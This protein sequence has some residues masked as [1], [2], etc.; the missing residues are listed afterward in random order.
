MSTSL[1]RKATFLI[2][3]APEQRFY[4]QLWRHFRDISCPFCC[5]FWTWVWLL[6]FS[7]VIGGSLRWDNHSS[8]CDSLGCSC[9]LWI[10]NSPVLSPKPLVYSKL[11]STFRRSEVIKWVTGTSGNLVVKSKLSPLSSSAALR[12]LNSIKKCHKGFY[13]DPKTPGTW[14]RGWFP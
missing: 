9:S 3:K 11:D 2:T 4:C 14:W 1:I 5:L 10:P 13:F 7:T 6:L 12:L 8:R